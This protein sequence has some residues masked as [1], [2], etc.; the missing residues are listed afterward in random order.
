MNSIFTND[1]RVFIGLIDRP[2]FRFLNRFMID[3]RNNPFLA[4]ADIKNRRI[5][6][7]PSEKNRISDVAEKQI[8]Q[9]RIMISSL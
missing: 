2:V 4:F 5:M 1:S 7:I 3:L 8:G 6:T 9:R